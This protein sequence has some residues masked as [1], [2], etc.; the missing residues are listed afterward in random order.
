MKR[1]LNW[2]VI[3]IAFVFVASIAVIFPT[4]RYLW[5]QNLYPDTPRE[6]LEE[7]RDKSPI[8]WG[9][10]LQ[11]GVDILLQ[12]D[13]EK[14]VAERLREL[15][16]DLKRNFQRD[17]V[18]ARFTILEREKALQIELADREDYKIANDYLQRFA[19]NFQDYDADALR[20]TGKVRLALK[21]EEIIRQAN[22]AIQ[23][24]LQVIRRRVDSLGLTQPSVAAQ[25]NDRIRIQLPGERDP[26]RVL[27]DIIRPAQLEF[28]L[29]HKDNEQLIQQLLDENYEFKPGQRAPDGYVLMRGEH[30]VH[31]GRTRTVVRN[32][33]YFVS[34]NVELTGEKLDRA[35]TTFIASDIESPVHVNLEFN[36]EGA[37]IFKEITER[38]IGRQLAIILDNYVYSAPLIKTVIPYGSAYISGNFTMEEGTALAQVLTAGSLKAPMTPEEKRVVGATLGV[39]S[40][41]SSV[42]AVLIGGLLVIAFMIIYYGTAGVI[43]DIALVLNVLLI[44]AVLSL[45]NATLTLSGVGGI[46]LT[47]GMAVDA[48][49]LIYERIREEINSGRERR[50]ALQLGFRRAFTVILDSNITT[51]ITALI[52]LQF[53]EGSVQGFA[54]TMA[55]GLIANLFT[56]LFVTGTLLT[57]YYEKTR[58]LSLGRLAMFRNTRIDFL[59]LRRIG[60]VIS[61]LL[62]LA[63]LTTL[64][65]HRGPIWGVEFTSGMIMHVKFEQPTEVSQLRAA[66]PE[67]R[68]QRAG[69]NEFLIR[70]KLMNDSNGVASMTLTENTVTEK[71]TQAY[72][73]QGYTIIG[74]SGVGQEIGK[75]FIRIALVSIIISCIFIAIY[76]AFRFQLAFGIGAVIALLH[77]ALITI[78][79]V[80]ILGHEMTLEVVSAI[81][82]VIGYSINDTIVIFDRIR[83]TMRTQVALGGFKEVANTAINRTLSRTIIMS[84]T[85]IIPIVILSLIGAQALKGFATALIIGFIVGTYSSTFVATPYVYW[86]LKWRS[87]KSRTAESGAQAR[88][89]AAR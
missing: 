17:K 2:K 79:G 76:I 21:E 4:L 64:I 37:I 55:I 52:L 60:F 43:A 63:S 33:P 8:K 6:R 18:N 38:N 12:V 65:Q 15:R 19:F 57:S 31:Q 28:R 9:L 24:N 84:G 74:V 35:F 13:R 49:V 70:M 66:I 10:D 41:R 80:T 39:D 26:E 72:G 59:G 25:G 20:E 53:A 88:V 1:G 42:K 83:E 81:L 56:G 54:L 85:T 87:G 89:A 23:G 86:W 50:A 36:K 7:L 82:I 40:I 67:A 11:G 48:N 58:R 14:V 75:E 44:F 32:Y 62:I 61:G 46:L 5:V 45:A 69:E 51:L 27:R 47:I 77:D 30:T 29:L 68:I 71:L 22:Q 16:D 34:Q 73:D 3:F 78:G